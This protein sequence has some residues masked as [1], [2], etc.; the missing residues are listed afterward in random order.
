MAL[1][2][3]EFGRMGI[4]DCVLFAG[5]VTFH[6]RCVVVDSYIFMNDVVRNARITLPRYGKKQSDYQQH[7][8]YEL[9]CAFHA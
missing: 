3:I 8:N 7:K 1:K 4:F 9:N 2:A 6:A 5:A